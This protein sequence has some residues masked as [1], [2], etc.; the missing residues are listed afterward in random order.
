MSLADK[1]ILGINDT[2]D[3]SA[4]II[5]NG[6]IICAISEER[7]QRVKSAGGFPRG[8]IN[9]CLKYA[10]L[11]MSDIHYIAV[12]G[13]RA[14][15]INLLGIN[16]TLSLKDY[17]A[18]QEQIRRP[19][20]YGGKKKSFK[21]IFPNYR[22]KANPF[23]STK[24]LPLKET[25][26]LT[27]KE[28][29]Y[30]NEYR[31]KFIAKETK[32]N[33]NNI[34]LFDHHLCHIYY[35][36]YSSPF[37]NV[38]VTAIS[39]DA[40]G[41]GLYETIST[42][43]KNS[44]HKRIHAGHECLLGPIYSMVTLLLKMK[45]NEHEFKVMGLAPYAKEYNKKYTRNFLKSIMS[46]KGIKF[47]RNPKMK[48]FYFYLSENLKNERFDGI[49]G[50]LQDWLE[51]TLLKWI[52]NILKKTKSKYLVFSGGVALN[53]KANQI[54]SN[55]K[56]IQKI[57]VPPGSGDESL[58]IGACWALM[59]KLDLKKKNKTIIYPLSNAYLGDD[60]N[61][62]EIREFIN[63]PIVKKKY[64][65]ISGDPDR[66]AA[67]S[68]MR[69]EIV[70]ICR[71]RMEFGPRSL[72]QRSLIANPSSKEIV[73]KINSSIK[74]RDFWMPF[75][76]S[77]MY[78]KINDCIKN[79]KKCDFSYMTFT[80]D[81]L[82]KAQKNF[83]ATLHPSDNTMRI[84]SVRKEMSPSFHRLLSF[85]YK[86]SGLPGVLNTSLNIHGKPIIKKPIDIV[87][88]LLKVPEIS[89]NNII[90]DKYFFKL[91]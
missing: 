11:K 47:K 9:A 21:D 22:P 87:N 7:I 64:K 57:F 18:I 32:K 37:R 19:Q 63:H 56:S 84:Q 13:T 59:D 69:N 66:L 34:F 43:D 24:K 61:D 23:Y 25:R 12:A 65:Q 31:I 45:P 75:A 40:G 39:L 2:H 52:T 82:A 33:V 62:S 15:P 58:S 79:N 81:S 68:L 54:I 80:S 1:Y 42:F 71:G 76:P 8:A 89:I 77:I 91:K 74:G 3:A 26:E 5:Y 67:Q 78:E 72:G 41:D 20:F 35:G 4:A 86:K 73:A 49:A 90:V 53:I 46:L 60:I 36:Y 48:D 30:I 38:N 10:G 88:E 70:A 44:I 55:L 16:S 28:K 85:F 29:K 17:I 51:S 14:V 50:G 83:I 6:K 27:L